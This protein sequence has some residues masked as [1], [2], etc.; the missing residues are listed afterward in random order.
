[1]TLTDRGPVWAGKFFQVHTDFSCIKIYEAATP[2]KFQAA[3][4]SCQILWGVLM[5]NNYLLTSIALCYI[6]I[7]V[8][9]LQ[10]N[11]KEKHCHQSPRGR[12]EL[13]GC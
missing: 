5:E 10:R 11:Q 1:M 6:K 7:N 12:G 13:Q 3:S 9:A 8:V 2:I 4:R